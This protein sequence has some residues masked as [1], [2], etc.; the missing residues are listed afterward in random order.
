[1]TDRAWILVLVVP[2]PLYV[3]GRFLFG[4]AL[5]SAALPLGFVLTFAFGLVTALGVLRPRPLVWAGELALLFAVALPILPGYPAGMIGLDLAAGVMLGAPFVGLERA[6]ESQYSPARRL[7]TLELIVFLGIWYLAALPAAAAHGGRL[8]GLGFFE[9]LSQVLG[10]QAQGLTALFT[11][12]VS[13][14]A[15]PFAISLDPF[16]VGLAAFALLGVMV[17]TLT[18]RTALDEPLPWGWIPPRRTGEAPD[19]TVPPEELREGQRVA[20]ATRSRPVAPEASTPPGVASLIL[21]ASATVLLTLGEIYLP[22]YFLT[23]QMF[24]VTALLVGV[25]I[26]LSRP[27]GSAESESSGGASGALSEREPPPVKLA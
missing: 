22:L 6:W 27:L 13:T 9:G 7:G 12:G 19:T 11:G 25:M 24:A 21:A 26:L 10:Q 4:S 2:A 15:L 17:T 5:D 3:A 1:M 20:L 14:A 8:S 23:L 16:F 18:P